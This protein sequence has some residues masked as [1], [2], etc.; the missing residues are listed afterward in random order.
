MAVPVLYS[1]GKAD[2]SRVAVAAGSWPL[3]LPLCGDFVHFL[4]SIWRDAG[5]FQ[6]VPAFDRNL[7]TLRAS[8]ENFL[9]SCPEVRMHN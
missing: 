5:I 3:H 8:V 6:L 7:F 2:E 1:K 4:C 9:Q